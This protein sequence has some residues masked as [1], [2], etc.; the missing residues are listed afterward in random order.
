[1]KSQ[2]SSGDLPRS[3]NQ[4]HGITFSYSCWIL[5]NDFTVNYGTKRIIFSK[6]DCPGLYLDT[7]SNALLFAVNTYGAKQTILIDNIPAGKWLHVALVVDQEAVDIYIDGTLKERNTLVQLP[8]QNTSP[9]TMGSSWDGVL[10]N[11]YYYPRAISS[12]EVQILSS[13]VP[14]AP[15]NTK[16]TRAD[17]DATWYT[18]RV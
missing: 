8:K 14:T 5:I 6:D 2:V 16:A 10:A 18:G 1:M 15:A 12:S 17:F 13:L 3:V 4:E 9:V 11:L 7:T